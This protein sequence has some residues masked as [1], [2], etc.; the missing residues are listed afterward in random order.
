MSTREG[1]VGV[2]PIEDLEAVI[3][4]EIHIQ[5]RTARK[6]FCGDSTRFGDAP[7]TNVCPV[8][9][10]LPGAL[11]VLNGEAVELA[12]RAALAFDC[13]VHETSIFARKNYF[14][15]DLPKGYQ[16]SQFEDPIASGG[17]FRVQM[18]AGEK[19]VRIRRMHMEEDAGKS[20]HDRV[21]GGTAVDLNRAGTPLV[22]MVSEPDLHSAEEARAYLQQVKQVLEYLDVS[23]C[24]MEEGSLRVDAN[25]SVRPAGTDTLGTKTE[26]KNMNSFSGVEKAITVE[27]ARQ[28][29]IVAEGGEVQHVTLLWDEARGEVRPMRSKEES[30]DYRYFPDPDLPPLV[31]GRDR[32]EAI[33]QALPELPAARRTR[34]EATYALPAYDAE[35][36]T[37]SRS[38]ADYF[39]AVADRSGDPKQS[40]NWVMGP[41]LAVLKE[42]GLDFESLSVSADGL[43]ELL[44]LVREGTISQGVAK[45]VLRKIFDSGRAAADIVQSE[46]LA[47]VRDVGQLE[48]WI[49]QVLDAHPDELTRFREGEKRLQGF[50]M[51]EVM[52][53]SRGKADPGEVARML[54][55]KLNAS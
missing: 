36:L 9:L 29:R 35:V 22:E 44:A 1:V 3:G 12:I 10:A 13:E 40:A 17:E 21:A 20:L 25:V 47:Q 14:Y 52:K 31:V 49:D 46:G 42:R 32:I 33:R 4:L 26:L 30:H 15:P 43:A 27:V 19:V 38:L 24:N 48:G 34:L 8:C 54:G 16:I 23:D 37:S 11:P 5:L 55:R 2:G 39:E 6:L 53:A 50:F 45:D 41:L 28:S 18:P 51:G 7:N